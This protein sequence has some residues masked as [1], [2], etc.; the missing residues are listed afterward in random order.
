RLLLRRGPDIGGSHLHLHAAHARDLRYHLGRAT[1]QGDLA[2]RRL[3]TEREGERDVRIVDVEV[4]DH[5]KRHDVLAE[6]GILDASK[7]IEDHTF[8]DVGASR[9]GHGAPELGGCVTSAEYKDSADMRQAN[10]R[11]PCVA[12]PWRT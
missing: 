5:P 3:A 1:V 6:I 9:S 7:G 12:K 2:R 10:G 4:L 11:V 8:R